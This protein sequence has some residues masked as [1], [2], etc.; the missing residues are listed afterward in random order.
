MHV[1]SPHEIELMKAALSQARE[2][3]SRLLSPS[4]DEIGE[5]LADEVRS[6][7]FKNQIKILVKARNLLEKSNIGPSKVPVKTLAPLLEGG[8]LEEEESILDCWANLLA[9]AANPA[10]EKSF[11]NAY[12][13]VLKQLSPAQVL[14]LDKLHG[15]YH[16]E[17]ERKRPL[18]LENLSIDTLDIQIDGADLFNLSSLQEEEFEAAMDNLVRLNLITTSGALLLNPQVG[19]QYYSQPMNYPAQFTRFGYH[20]VS[21]CKGIVNR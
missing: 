12:I 3:L 17:L 9:N 4:V 7:R 16:K 8:S 5:L 15:Y 2:F 20:F 11:D 13:E 14:I 10:H 6:F 1:P 18:T 19:E 21:S